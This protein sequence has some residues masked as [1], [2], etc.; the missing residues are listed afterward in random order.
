VDVPKKVR[1]AL[2]ILPITHMDEVVQI[3][4]APDPIIEPPRPR[5]RQEEPGEQEE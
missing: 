1:E 3:A 5:R 2:K 4:I